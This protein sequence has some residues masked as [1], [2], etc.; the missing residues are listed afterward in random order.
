MYL[1]RFSGFINVYPRR[2]IEESLSIRKI[3]TKKKPGFVNNSRSLFLISVY[4]S[5]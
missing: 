1:S 4:D 2:L 5:L 3:V